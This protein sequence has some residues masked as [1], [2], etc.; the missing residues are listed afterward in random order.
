V[1][2]QKL[3]LQ[4]AVLQI[5]MEFMEKQMKTDLELTIIGKEAELKILKDKVINLKAE[6]NTLKAKF[7]PERQRREWEG[8]TLGLGH[9]FTMSIPDGERS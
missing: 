4:T 5:S 2:A 6:L 8:V 9:G 3:L 7:E 1:A